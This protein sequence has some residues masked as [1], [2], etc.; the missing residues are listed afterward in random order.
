[1]WPHPHR[2]RVEDGPKGRRVVALGRP[3]AAARHASPLGL[4]VALD[5]VH[6]HV[7]LDRGKDLLPFGDAQPQGGGR[8]SI[9]SF[10]RRDLVFRHASRLGFRHQLDTPAHR[11]SSL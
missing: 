6:H 4:P 5:L 1:M 2:H 9:A 11:S 10:E 8:D 7:G 3:R